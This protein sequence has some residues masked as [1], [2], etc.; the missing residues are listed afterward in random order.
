VKRVALALAIG[1]ATAAVS[2]APPP[3]PRHG[4][5]MFSSE[6]VGEQSGD[7]YG[8]RITVRRIGKVD[9]LV[10]ER[11]DFAAEVIWPLL[12]EGNGYRL[13]FESRAGEATPKTV[14]GRISRD[15]MTLELRGLPFASPEHRELLKRVTD[16]SRPTPVCRGA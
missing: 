8:V 11:A 15:G 9:D 6:C 3:L 5:V 12:L 2:A 14:E 4:L 16:F 7:G 10:L 13:K 1:A